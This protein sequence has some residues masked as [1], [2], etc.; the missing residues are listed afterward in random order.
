MTEFMTALDQVKVYR[1]LATAMAEFCNN[2]C[3]VSSRFIGIKH[4]RKLD[5]RNLR[6]VGFVTPGNSGWLPFSDSLFFSLES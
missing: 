5:G 4:C 2:S 3:S 1:E 6:D